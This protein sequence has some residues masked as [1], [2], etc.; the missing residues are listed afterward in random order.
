MSDGS[1][2]PTSDSL[3]RGPG[4]TQG[5]VAMVGQFTARL[6]PLPQVEALGLISAWAFSGLWLRPGIRM[7]AQTPCMYTQGHAPIARA[8]TSHSSI[9]YTLELGFSHSSAPESPRNLIKARGSTSGFDS[10]GLG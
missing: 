3:G 2:L 7:P 10:V 9:L 6:E 4:T 5:Q 8:S 1:L